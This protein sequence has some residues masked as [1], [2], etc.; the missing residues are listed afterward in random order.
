MLAPV[1]AA[2]PLSGAEIPAKQS[3]R[4]GPPIWAAID[5]A[6]CFFAVFGHTTARNLNETGEAMAKRMVLWCVCAALLLLM[7]GLFIFLLARAPGVTGN[8]V[9][10]VAGGYAHAG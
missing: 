7:L 5:F 4:I 8:G 9:R 3:Q 2:G 10:F 6:A 1:R